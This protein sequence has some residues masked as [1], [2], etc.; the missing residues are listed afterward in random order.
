[1]RVL[2]NKLCNLLPAHSF[3]DHHADDVQQGRVDGLTDI[4]QFFAAVVN[5]GAGW[6]R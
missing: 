1:M 2:H 6:D 4:A 5:N 3:G